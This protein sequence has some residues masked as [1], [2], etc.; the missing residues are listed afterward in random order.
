[1]SLSLAASIIT[2]HIYCIGPQKV[3]SVLFFKVSVPACVWGMLL[4]P[5][6]LVD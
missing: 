5:T 1:M 2:G 4:E 3:N 6:F